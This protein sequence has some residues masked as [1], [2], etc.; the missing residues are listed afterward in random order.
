MPT[1]TVEN[2]PPLHTR[3]ASTSLELL[4]VGEFQQL[5][6]QLKELMLELAIASPGDDRLELIVY[7][8]LEVKRLLF[9]AAMDEPS[10]ADLQAAVEDF[11]VRS[12]TVTGGVQ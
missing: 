10:A 2:K 1:L 4:P 12:L 6:T 11:L 9:T 7:S 8:A 5:F 3:P